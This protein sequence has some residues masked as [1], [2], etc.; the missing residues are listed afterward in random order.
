MSPVPL[1][2]VLIAPLARAGSRQKTTAAWRASLSIS[3]REVRLPVSSSEVNSAVSGRRGQAPAWRNRRSTVR[4]HGDAAFHIQH[5][6]AVNF[7]I[8]FAEGLA[9]QRAQVENRIDVAQDQHAARAVAPAAADV[10]AGLLL[11]EDLHIHR[12]ASAAR[13]SGAGPAG[14]RRLYQWRAI[15]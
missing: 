7:A 4:Q 5:A 13:G 2:A 8:R 11:R 12:P 1:R 14:R 3:A 10:I 15:R 9:G 6:G